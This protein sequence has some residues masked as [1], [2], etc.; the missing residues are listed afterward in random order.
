MAY[1]IGSRWEYRIS[2]T[3]TLDGVEVVPGLRAFDNNLD[4]VEVVA[5]RPFPDKTP[6]GD[7]IWWE[8]RNLDTGEPS[9]MQNASRLTFWYPGTD[10]TA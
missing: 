8:M 4:R 10:R 2:A 7:D 3:H 5:A 6:Y 1:G 9:P